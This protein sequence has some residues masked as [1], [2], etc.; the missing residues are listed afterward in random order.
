MKNLKNLS[1]VV[2]FVMISATVFSQS[3]L[4]G[5]IVDETGPLPGAN[6]I[7]KGTANGTTTDFDGNFSLDSDSESGEVVISF[8]GYGSLTVAFNGTSNLGTLTLESDSNSL[9]EVVIVG[10]G[11]IDLADDRKTPVAVSTITAK[12]IQ[13]KIGTQDI[14]MTLVNTPSVYVSGQSGGYGD[15]RIAVR[16]FQQDNTAY[17]LNGQPINGMED[18]KMYWSNWSGMSDIANVVQMQRGLGSSKL[19]ISSVGGTVNFVTKSTDKRESGFAYAGM[20]NDNY[21][22]GTIAYNTGRSEKG[23][24]TSVMFS[25]WQGDGYNEGTFGKGQNY[26][27]SVGYQPNERHNFNFLITGAPQWHDQNFSKSI[28][29]Y[30]EYGVK[31]NDNWGTYKGEYMTERRNFYHKPVA[32]LNWDFNINETTNLSTVLYASWGR[33]G[34]TGGRGNKL[35]TDDGYVDYDAIY[36]F[37]ESVPGGAGG[38]F[39]AGGGYVTRSSVNSHSWYGLV[40]NLEKKLSENLTLNVGIDYRYYYGF[41]HRVVENFHGLTSWQEDIKLRD[42]NNNHERYGGWGEYKNVIATK[43]FDAD[44]WKALTTK[45]A[46]DQKIAYSNDERIT[47]G[48]LFGQLEYANENFSAFFQGSISNQGHQRFDHYQYADQ[49]LIDGTSSQNVLGDNGQPVPLPDDIV[50]GNDSEKVNNFGFNMKGGAGYFIDASNKL[51][52]N[53]GYYSRQ[54]YQ[55]NI[56]LNFTNQINPLTQNEK[57]F[58]LE[59]GYSYSS[60]NFS[61]NVNLYRTSWKDRVVTSS[62]VEDD[63]VIYTTNEGVEQLHSGLEIDATYRP[64]DKLRLQGFVSVG[65]WE[66]KGNSVTRISDEDQN[67]IDTEVVDVDGGKVGDAAQ[68]TLGFGAD[69]TI[70]ERLSVDADFRFYDNLYADV[71]AVKNNLKLPSYGLLDFGTSYKLLIGDM[72]SLDF[73]L[74]INNA[75]DKEY[76]SELSTNIHAGDDDASGVTYEGIDVKNRGYFGLGRTWN[77]SLRFNF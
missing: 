65:S 75:L 44:P 31:Y 58:G 9:E 46:E 39:T 43:F 61:G 57:I 77:F 64:I 50:P 71:G 56:Y 11:I 51:Y 34:G 6:V 30:L 28:D 70:I 59:L 60:S 3:T 14:T 66:F 10:T 41:H 63:I 49:S 52:A 68:F 45:A 42:Q 76:L 47:Y 15:S 55:D 40:S 53:I 17:L 16:G 38:N 5:T 33:G 32:N 54:P 26:F 29:K 62:D 19:A 69:Y 23:W 67:V 73:R 48:G 35:E 37:N 4:T 24:G 74:N 21:F 20:A 18:G 36:A 22:K 25:H 2:L 7:E 12:E 8:V 13:K 1:M 27:I 72:Y